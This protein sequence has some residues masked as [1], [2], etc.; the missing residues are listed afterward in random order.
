[1]KKIAKN[2]TAVCISAA[3]FM[4]AG[5]THASDNEVVV[6]NNNGDEAHAIGIARAAIT[7]TCLAGPQ[8]ICL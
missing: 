3:L 8:A 7:S 5:L 6:L 2:I 1:M 4:S